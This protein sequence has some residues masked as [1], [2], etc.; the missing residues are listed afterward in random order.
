MR[1]AALSAPTTLARIALTFVFNSDRFCGVAPRVVSAMVSTLP[2][3]S[4]SP[5]VAEAFTVMGEVCTIRPRRSRSSGGT[6]TFRIC[7]LLIGTGGTGA[8]V[9]PGNWSLSVVSKSS[10]LVLRKSI[11]R[12]S[13]SGGLKR[14]VEL[15]HDVAEDQPITGRGRQG[16]ADGARVHDRPEQI[17]V[18]RG[19]PQLQHLRRARRSTVERPGDRASNTQRGGVE[20]IH[21]R[22][23]DGVERAL[24]APCK[25]TTESTVLSRL[26]SSL[27]LPVSVEMVTVMGLVRTSR[28]SKSRFKGGRTTVATRIGGGS[29]RGEAAHDRARHRLAEYE[30]AGV[31]PA[32][33]GGLPQL[34]ARGHGVEGAD[35]INTITVPV[36]RDRH[37]PD[38]TEAEDAR[39]GR[40]GVGRLAQLPAAILED[41]DPVA[42]IAIPVAHHRHSPGLRRTGRC[43]HWQLRVK[44]RRRS[45]HVEVRGSKVPMSSRPSPFQSPT[46]AFEPGVPNWNVPA[47]AGPVSAAY[48]SD[49]VAVVVSKT[50]KSSVPS[51]FQSPTTAFEPGALN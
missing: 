37:R 28:P 8:G 13:G 4:P 48:F 9:I 39:V 47:L 1:S 12:R 24:L 22:V 42:A 5:V 25:F 7:P 27:P 16:D 15:R 20:Q 44:C 49:Q 41:A 30:V 40:A 18:D 17:Q 43:R 34:P 21:R 6:V 36:A 23:E 46:T 31:G 2:K 10:S 26:P 19:H 51:P 38:G 14:S 32:S 35:A 29:R 3:R 11:S 50:P 45:D 33:S